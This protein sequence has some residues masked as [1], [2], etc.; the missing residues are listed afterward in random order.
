[1]DVIGFLSD[2]WWK[3]PSM[4]TFVFWAV[5][6]YWGGKQLRKRVKYRRFERLNS[7]TDGLFILGFMVLTCDLMWVLV[8][9]SRF[10][11][12]YISINM[13]SVWQMILVAFRDLVGILFCFLLIGN[14]FLKGIVKINKHTIIMYLVNLAFLLA[15]FYLAPSP[16]WTDWTYAIRYDY[17]FIIVL[18]SF[19][20]SHVVGKSIVA[21][22][23]LTIWRS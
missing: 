3:S 10:G 9:L 18:E 14:Y 4:W 2:W 22:L 11:A 16:A 13:H 23:Y 19:V 7:F 8:C 17:P 20:V 15:W 12:L 6:A 21:V 1:M 5:L